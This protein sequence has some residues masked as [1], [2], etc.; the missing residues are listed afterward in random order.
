[1]ST[2]PRSVA[3]T[4]STTSSQ[5]TA[6]PT[7]PPAATRQAG[8]ERPGCPPGSTR[9]RPAGE[10]DADRGECR[11]QRHDRPVGVAVE[12]QGEAELEQREASTTRPR[13]I[14]AA[15]SCGARTRGSRLRFAPAATGSGLQRVRPRRAGRAGRRRGAVP[16]GSA[17]GGGGAA[18]APGPDRRRGR[19]G[20]Q[21]GQA[22]ARSRPG[23]SA[24]RPSHR[25][26]AGGGPGAAVASPR[27]AGAAAGAARGTAACRRPADGSPGPSAL[28][29]GLDG[30]LGLG[31]WLT[32]PPCALPVARR[33]DRSAPH[34]NPARPR[35]GGRG[36][37]AGRRPRVGRRE[38]R[39]PASSSPAPRCSPA[40]SPT[41]TG[42][43]WPSS[44]GSW[45]STS[46]TS[47]WW[48]TGP[49]TCAR[50]W[51]SSPAP[52]STWSITSG[53]LGPTADDLTAEV[54][55]DFQGRPSALDPALER[56]IAAIVER[57]MARRG[58]RA[59]PAATAAGVRKQALVPA[60]ATVL[61]PVGT[62]PGLVVP[63]AEGRSG[64]TVLVL[65]GPAA[66]L[67]GMWPAARGGRA[68]AAGARRAPGAAPG[69]ACGCG[70]RSRRSWPPRCATHEAELAGLE[71]TTCLRDGELEIVTRFGPGRRSP[72][73]TGCG[74]VL[75]RR[76]GG[77]ALLHRPDARR[78]GGAG[79]RRARADR[80]DGGVLH[81]RAAR[82]RG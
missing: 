80:R 75:R 7:S 37:P 13:P 8:P 20:A 73:T 36:A 62:A 24:G 18:C 44:C 15:R 27:G 81:R 52:A 14:R 78:P 67:Q 46:G 39:A 57:L 16:A 71:I 26:R 48:A 6:R 9:R 10:H 58:W 61:D 43:G 72:P 76:Y 77:H 2:K 60:G 3:T 82:R 51:P 59:D 29:R 55:G 42:P 30:R 66:E 17:A 12:A 28:P 56:R 41:A 50:P 35:A 53:G 25:A 68:G 64:P 11:P 21:A 34:R 40:G 31:R 65:P 69:D 32:G 49:R 45:A 79:V 23:R 1:M 47:S 5:K 22:R 4:G 54:V 70:A 74:A 19:R 33:S 38:Q 63:P